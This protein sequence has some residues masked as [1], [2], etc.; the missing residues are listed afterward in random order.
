Y[1]FFSSRRRH[2]RFSRDWSSDVCSS[3]LQDPFCI[4]QA[5]PAKEP[6]VIQN[7]IYSSFVVHKKRE[8]PDLTART[9]KGLATLRQIW[10]HIPAKPVH[11]ISMRVSFGGADTT[12]CVAERRSIARFSPVIGPV[13]PLLNM[14]QGLS[15]HRLIRVPELL[16]KTV[17]RIIFLPHETTKVV[18]KACTI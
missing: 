6:E 1:F 3:D 17:L 7:Y 18:S 11:I 15:Q 12:Q 14:M 2:T 8:L 13:A 5:L 9:T 4:R 10:S 16:Q